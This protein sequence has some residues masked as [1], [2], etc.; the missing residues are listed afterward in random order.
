MSTD[1]LLVENL[2]HLIEQEKKG[3][4]SAEAGGNGKLAKEK[5]KYILSMINSLIKLD[6]GSAD[7]YRKLQ[8]VW[9]KK[10]S[11]I[12]EGA[13][14]RRS[15]SR[16]AGGNGESGDS[17]GKGGLIDEM[18]K[19]FTA[20]IKALISK[21]NTTWDQIGGL[22]YEKSLL[23]EAVFFAAAS[24]EINVEVPNLKNILLYGPPGTGKTTLAKAVSSTLSATFFNVPLSE[25]MSRYVGDSERLVKSLFKVARNTAPSVVFI[26]EIEFLFKDREDPTNSHTTGVLQ[27][28]LR[29]LDGFTDS[30]FVMVI[31]ATNQ[32]WKLDSAILSRFEKRIYVSPPDEKTR[33]TILGIHT[34]KKGYKVDYDLG[35]LAEHTAGFSGRDLAYLCN[36]AIRSMLRRANSTLINQVDGNNGDSTGDRKYHISDITEEDF[37]M[38][39]KNVRPVLNEEMMGKFQN[40]SKEFGGR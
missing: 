1:A 17:S 10:L 23:K 30:G 28:F 24:P 25:L 7:Y 12:K 5:C 33:E 26:D 3:V 35:S 29:Q 34:T 40:W 20:R 31:A 2:K 22:D 9:E 19:E 4:Q 38:A 6:P 15:G 21:D 14:P 13:P 27:E 39:L 11:Q 36:E 8:G 37:G 16:N 32:P 18:E